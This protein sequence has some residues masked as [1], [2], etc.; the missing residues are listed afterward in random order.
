MSDLTNSMK[1]STMSV[2]SGK[3]KVKHNTSTTENTTNKLGLNNPA[4]WYSGGFI[5]L[6]VAIALYDGELLS[7]IVNAGFSWAV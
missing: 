3:S 4:F 1:A 5:A 2:S 6:F 7:T